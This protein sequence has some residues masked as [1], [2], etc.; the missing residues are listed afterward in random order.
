MVVTAV[1]AL[2]L[3]YRS[4]L[5]P[6]P[7]LVLLLLLVFFGPVLPLVNTNSNRVLGLTNVAML[8]G[9]GLTVALG[10][11]L[12]P[13][14]SLAFVFVVVYACRKLRVTRALFNDLAYKA[15]PEH[16]AFFRRYC[17]AFRKV[18]DARARG[19]ASDSPR[20]G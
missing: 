18:F 12:V 11:P 14:G 17:E 8:F 6:F 16:D 2:L 15:R 1:T 9:L 5:V 3:L 4:E 13:L 7:V 10:H 20:Q 19:E